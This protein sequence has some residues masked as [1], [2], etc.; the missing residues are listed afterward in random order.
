MSGTINLGRVRPIYKGNYNAETAYSVLE[1]VKYKG[2][3]YECV[4]NTTPGIA[5]DSADNGSAYWTQI[6][7]N[8]AIPQPV[9]TGTELAFEYPDGTITDAVDLEGPQGPQGVPGPINLTSD[10]TSTAADVALT[11][12]GGNTLANRIALLQTIIKQGLGF[13]TREIIT[14][15]GEWTA[16]VTGTYKITLIGGGSGGKIALPS[17]AGGNSGTIYSAFVTLA[18]DSTVDVSI[19]AGGLADNGS[20][21]DVNGGVTTF[22]ELASTDALSFVEDAGLAVPDLAANTLTYK[23]VI[24]YKDGTSAS[25]YG[26]SGGFGGGFT[27]NPAAV[28]SQKVIANGVFFGGGG[29]ATSVG[30]SSWAGKGQQGCVIIEYFDPE[31]AP[32]P[33]INDTDLIP[34]INLL[35]RLEAIEAQLN[36]NS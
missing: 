19:G 16:P 35:Q 8:N 15:S 32:L 2:H 30:A 24:S 33:T 31:K 3:I 36:I 18:K 5:P 26:I 21:I 6:S 22:G 12:L 29:S 23:G 20:G 10:L 34:Y 11:A 27:V 1:R 4:A 17:V 13:N 7:V 28:E 9:W 14:E 25:A